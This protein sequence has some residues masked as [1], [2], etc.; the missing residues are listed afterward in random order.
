M[1]ELDVREQ[2]LGRFA[3]PLSGAARRRIV[4]WHDADG[5]FEED[6]DA[7]AAAAEAGELPA[8]ERPLWFLKAEDGALFSAKRTLAREDT[9]SDFAVYRQRPAGDVAGDL[10]A[11][12]ELYAEHFQAD[13]LSLI[14]QAVGAADTSELR[15]AISELRTFFAAKPRVAAFAAVMPGAS[16]GADVRPGCWRRRWAKWRP[17]PRPSCGPSPWR[18]WPTKRR[19]R[20]AAPWASS[21]ATEPTGRSRATWRP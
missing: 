6:F 10:L 12:I 7:L 19:A 17:R 18:P 9:A 11:D 15:A 20:P 5:E 8:G 13:G 4:I 16:S 2:F 1:A 21:H 14:V 3:E